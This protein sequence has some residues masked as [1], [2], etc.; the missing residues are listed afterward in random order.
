MADI[1]VDSV[2]IS[3]DDRYGSDYRFDSHASHGSRIHLS[4]REDQ[5]T[6][7]KTKS[8]QMPDLT[9][10]SSSVSLAERVS[11]GAIEESPKSLLE[12]LE[13]IPAEH[14]AA[15]EQAITDNV[16]PDQNFM[17]KV[18]VLV[19]QILAQLNRI[20]ENDR[21]KTEKLKTKYRT[22]TLEAANLQR[23]CGK[24]GLLFAGIVFG[25]S[26]LQFA[27]PNADDRSIA[28]IFANQVCEKTGQLF[29]AGLRADMGQA[30]N[31][32]NLLLQEYQA[33]ASKG[34]SD[35]SNKQEITGM[36]EKALRLLESA[37]RSG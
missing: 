15:V 8:L 32:A 35:S 24:N 11:A 22:A 23:E 3:D 1:S 5:T 7:E 12:Q 17:L 34:S 31:L 36:L 16:E 10:F 25:T 6:I 19:A 37:A 2:P 27:S 21:E 20:S 13:E 14:F 29:D 18:Q 26:L 9:K 33:K 4:A 30:T 28:N